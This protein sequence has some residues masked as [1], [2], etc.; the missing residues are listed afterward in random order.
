M[1]LEHFKCPPK[2]Y[3]TSP[4]WSWNDMLSD[5]ELC[6][7]VQE[8]KK[9]GFGGFFMHAREGLRTPYLSQTWFDSISAAVN[10][11]EKQN[12]EAWL[13]DEDRWP[14]GCAG[15]IVTA[16]ED[17]YKAK[18]LLMQFISELEIEQYSTD[19]STVA[20]FCLKF[21][22]DILVKFERISLFDQ[23]K[24]GEKE[25]VGEKVLYCAFLIK[26]QKPT[27]N[28]NGHG[29]IDVL[30]PKAVKEFIR[31]THTQYHDKTGKYFG[32]VIPGIFA[33][34]PTYRSKAEDS[35]PW[36]PEFPRYFREHH[37]YDV[38]DNLPLLFFDCDK[39]AKVRYHYFYTLTKKFVECFTLEL[40][41]WCSKH[42][43]QFTG[44]YLSEDTMVKQTNAIGSAMAHY[45]YMHIPGIDHLGNNIHDALTLKQCASIGSQFK[46]KR[47]LCE[48]FGV[49]GH[50]MTFE[51]QKWIANFHFA[52]GITFLSQHLVLYSMRG[53]RKRDYPPTFSYH[54]PYWSY[55]N[56]INDYMARASYFC[57]QGEYLCDTLVLHPIGSV[58]ATFTRKAGKAVSSS[59]DEDLV[60][61]QNKLFAAQIP[62][63]YGDELVM[64]K[65]AKVI[66]ENNTYLQV[67][68]CKYSVVII[69]PSLTWSRFTYNLLNE[70][71]DHGGK[72]VFLEKTP[73]MIEGENAQDAWNKLYKNENVII[74]SNDDQK[75][76]SKLAAYC[77]R[78]VEIKT[79]SG[80]DT[81]NILIHTR[82]KGDSYYCFI[83]NISRDTSQSITV[84]LPVSGCVQQLDFETGKIF[85]VNF[86]KDNGSL[87][88]DVTLPPAGSCGY[89]ITPEYIGQIKCKIAEDECDNTVIKAIPLQEL[90]KFKRT[91]KN[92][93]TLDYCRYSLNESEW[94]KE[95]PVWQV[96]HQLW[97]NA[98]LEEFNG[99]QPWVVEKQNKEVFKQIPVKIRFQFNVTDIGKEIGL[100]LENSDNWDLKVNGVKISTAV[101]RYYWD[102]QFGLIDISQAVITGTNIIEIKGIYQYGVDIE[103]IYLV[104]DFAVQQTSYKT[105]TI[106]KEPRS[107]NNGSWVYQGYPFYAGN[108]V[109]K[110]EFT[111]P[112]CAKG[113]SLWVRLNEPRGTL[114]NVS[115]NNKKCS[116]L[117]AQ[118]W[119]VDITDFCDVGKN[120]LSIEVVGSLR[121]TFGPLHHRTLT[122]GWCGPHQFV[123]EYNWVESYQF[124][125][126][127]L[128]KGASLIVKQFDNN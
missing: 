43:I 117:I 8:M 63:D 119:E 40:Y 11:A 66:E 74:L 45:Q 23:L 12:M 44:H 114:F 68:H 109:Y 65:N 36:S 108:M 5:N 82:G 4:F 88:F 126:Y 48:I 60:Q 75:I 35:M 62:F 59:Y 29:Y 90:W 31:V 98:G 79:K 47:L 128:L 3:R 89:L 39:S 34:E 9:Q 96:R 54:Q 103:D 85:M 106:T 67:G 87:S 100:V 6:W 20:V 113:S 123:D 41:N 77:Y 72:V 76:S 53:E 7:Q 102:K 1:K 56:K 50:Q 2:E 80:E 111:L 24:P 16:K 30:N 42:G 69:P 118:P 101:D 71:V 81:S 86:K 58:W 83:T 22:G 61:L 104:G 14:S 10:E 19:P 13:Y 92:S 49:S 55:Y 33:D 95:L 127:G 99:V 15:G 73:N 112:S 84:M 52:L 25:A 110:T 121:N 93:M 26:I 124:E 97:K 51:D 78:P 116:S 57:S 122:P 94:S 115:V 70:F 125:D 17:E 32:T 18:Y 21:D 91:H 46:R 38:V 28:S 64:E 120:Q 27:N 105:Y 37:N 107:L